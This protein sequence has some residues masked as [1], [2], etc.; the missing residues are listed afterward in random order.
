MTAGTKISRASESTRSR[1]DLT[2]FLSHRK[3]FLIG[4]YNLTIQ[5]SNFRVN[6]LTYNNN[7]SFK[8]TDVILLRITLSLWENVPNRYYVLVWTL[9][10]KA[11]DD[12]DTTWC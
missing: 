2:Y 7:I 10:F 5:M 9:T 1:G 12:C 4:S 6:I 8:Q 11:R 3:I